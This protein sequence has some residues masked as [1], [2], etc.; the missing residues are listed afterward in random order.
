LAPKQAPSDGS[1]G[2]RGSEASTAT[3]VLGSLL[4]QAIESLT[5][6]ARRVR[7]PAGA[8]VF[9]QGDAGDAMY[10]VESGLVDIFLGEGHVVSGDVAGRTGTKDGA[11]RLMTLG[12]GEV[13]GEQSLL[14]GRPRSASAVTQTG[15]TLLRIDHADFLEAVTSDPKLGAAVAGVLSQRLAVTSR[16]GVG[17]RKGQTALVLGEH[18]RV[19]GAVVAPLLTACEE[20]LASGCLLVAPSDP[21]WDH[22]GLPASTLR[23][24][25][26]DITGVV[27]RAVREYPLVVVA[28]TAALPAEL[29]RGCDRAVVLGGFTPGVCGVGRRDVRL[30][31]LLD[32]GAIAGLARDLCGRRVGL[33]LGA[34]AIRGFAHAGVLAV[35]DELALPVDLVSGASAGAIAAA[36]YLRGHPPR[37]LGDLT[38]AFV[39]ALGTGWSPSLSLSP[40]SLLPGRR[41]M[42][43]FTR[44]LGAQTLI[45][46]LPKPLVIAT[47]DLRTRSTVHLESGPLAQ[48]V[49]ASSAIPGIFPSVSIAG[50]RL[51]DGGTSDPVPVRALRERGADIVVAVN[52]MAMNGDVSRRWPRL[53]LPAPLE[54]LLVLPALLDNLLTGFD[55]VMSQIAADS[56]RWADVVV[57]PIAPRSPLHGV[58]PARAY[59]RAGERAM[60]RALPELQSLVGPVSVTA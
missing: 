15:A 53:T 22:A 54:R 20:L 41:L 21:R 49:A 59:M 23:V 10:V 2:G 17:L 57:T 42:R 37:E 60:Q 25:H 34:G 56:C 33:A 1:P 12:P 11:I 32:A 8:T 9:A 28:G 26:R 47:T 13:V 58:V 51:V 19:V 14:T 6:V 16:R 40:D 52:V 45:E 7:L 43:F 36:L 3:D 39:E 35:L 5:R 44:K 4:P 27:V 30:P 38:K 55:V 48:A 50:R 46:D 31:E 24:A 29:V 18:P